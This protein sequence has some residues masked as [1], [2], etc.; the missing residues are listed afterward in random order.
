[1]QILS[2]CTHIWQRFEVKPSHPFPFHLWGAINSKVS[3]F[4]W[5][6]SAAKK[7]NLCWQ[8]SNLA[9][10]GNNRN[11][12]WRFS[13][14]W[15]IWNFIRFHRRSLWIAADFGDF[16]SLAY[17]ISI[18]MSPVRKRQLVKF[19]QI[20]GDNDPQLEWPS[21]R[22]GS[23]RIHPINI[24]SRAKSDLATCQASVF[25]Q[26]CCIPY[27]FYIFKNWKIKVIDEIFSFSSS[28]SGRVLFTFNIRVV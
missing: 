3:P 20:C 23:G 14:T 15:A 21:S 17:K 8:T 7:R 22:V 26:T 28:L 6:I 11:I 13:C 27:F 5:P 4:S 12:L 16:P 19:V 1:M 2:K 24:Q 25:A 9:S 10:Q 18:L